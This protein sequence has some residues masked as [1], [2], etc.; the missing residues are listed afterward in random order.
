LQK[1]LK[2][3]NSIIGYHCY[4]TGP[5]AVIC[6]HGYGEQGE[7][8]VFLEKHAGADFTFY[9][10]DLP[11]HH[12]TKWNE[13]LIF[14]PLDLNQIVHLI[15]PASASPF[16]TLHPPFTILGYSLGGRMALSLYEQMPE[17]ISKI[18]LLA[19]DGLKV[20][21]W[22]WL[23]T[24]TWAGNKLFALTMRKPGWFLCLLQVM[25]RFSF[26]NT[27]IYKFVKYY[28]GNVVVREQLYQRWTAL[29]KIKPNLSR[30]KKAILTHH[31]PTRLLYGKHDRIIL[32]VN[33]EKF[34]KGIE[35]NCTLTVIDAGHAVLGERYVTDIMENLKK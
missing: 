21:G 31:T 16:S 14:T 33:G 10:I 30:I 18:I 13:G 17:R 19:P 5:Q 22:Y 20:N 4:G 2:Y 11:F 27:S 29:R 32:S 15:L 6:F 25:N 12:N 34:R 24:Q 28:I 35:D 7:N 1:Q 8:F 3:K 9:A 26:I 23:A